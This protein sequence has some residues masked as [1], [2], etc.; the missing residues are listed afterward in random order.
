[1]TDEHGFE[2]DP[3]ARSSDR[4][5]TETPQLSEEDEQLLAYWWQALLMQDG[6]CMDKKLILKMAARSMLDPQ[7][8][9]GLVSDSER[10]LSEL[11]PEDADLPSGVTLRFL[12]NTEQVLNIILPRAMEGVAPAD[13]PALREL[14]KSRT[15]DDSSFF[16]DDF[17]DHGNAGDLGPF[18]GGGDKGDVTND[19]A[20]VLPE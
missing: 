19:A 8:R 3:E 12:E 7:F 11:L 17:T 13:R 15:S 6:R 2:S 18:L 16:R 5:Q 9:A 14:L 4:D 20:V 10:M 1:M